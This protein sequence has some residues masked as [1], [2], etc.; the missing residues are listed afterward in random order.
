MRLGSVR[1]RTG[2]PALR[3]LVISAVALA[4][5]LVAAGVAL[6]T[7]YQTYTDPAGD[8]NG[9]PDVTTVHV[10]NDPAGNLTFEITLAGAPDLTGTEVDANLDTDQNPSTGDTANNSLGID[11]GIW[12]F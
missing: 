3:G 2:L 4:T 11:N 5:A 1:G 7:N 8:N 12:V 10:S 6:G 9:A